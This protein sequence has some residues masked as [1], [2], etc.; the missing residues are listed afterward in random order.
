MKKIW[1][2]SVN[3]FIYAGFA[4]VAPF[5][6][7]FY[8]EQGFT[9]VQ[10]GLLT[11]I[12]PLVTFISAPLWTRLADATRRHR[13]IMSLALLLGAVAISLF[14]FLRTFLPLLLLALGFNAFFAPVS[15]F[16]DS[17][18]MYMLGDEKEMYGRIR[19][20][21]TI[22]FGLAPPL[23]GLLVQN[24]GLAYAFW[25]CGVMFLLALLV[26]QKLVYGAPKED[27][28]GEGGIV[29]LLKKPRW[30]I[31]LTLAFAGGIGTTASNLF[32][33]P[34]LKELGA[35]ESVMGLALMIGIIAELP[36]MFF[37]NRLIKYF[38]SYG[39]L[40]L[41]IVLTGVRFLLLAATGNYTLVLFIQ[42]LNGMTFPAM[43]LAGVSYADEIAPTDLRSTA[44]GLFGAMVFGI[45]AAVGG[46]ISGP[47]L[48]SIGGQGLF[49]VLGITILV[50]VTAAGLIQRRL[51]D[52]ILDANSF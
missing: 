31:F 18:T 25:G 35:S 26:S 49:L 48:E 22:A 10:I 2:F 21:G 50:I 17:A 28:A 8:Q 23:A 33:F 3:V 47:L 40:L 1:P 30:L 11:G 14:P 24:Y 39:L 20:G 43:W 15:S 12:T 5:M 36:V 6:V 38:K 42:I 29:S 16:N 13:L 34:Y 9:G 27:K 4:F 7:L 52:H 19:I 37:G 41:A 46:F 45:G 44:Q 32:F 51:A